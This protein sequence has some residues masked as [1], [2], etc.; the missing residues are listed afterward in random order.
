MPGFSLLSNGT[1]VEERQGW[2]LAQSHQRGQQQLSYLAGRPNLV[3]GWSWG[4]REKG[5]FEVGSGSGVGIGLGIETGSGLRL[6]QV[7]KVGWLSGRGNQQNK[8]STPG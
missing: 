6:G 2:G 1:N 8:G 4:H 5:Y 7:G 3:E